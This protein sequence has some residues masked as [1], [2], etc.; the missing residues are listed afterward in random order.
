MAATLR[1][2]P[3]R[4]SGHCKPSRGYGTARRS[5]TSRGRRPRGR[6]PAELLAQCLEDRPLDETL[7]EVHLVRVEAHRTRDAPDL[8]GGLLD[9]RLDVLALQEVLDDLGAV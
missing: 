5:R 2:T 7:R 6:R 8:S 4:T 1:L 9:R 3:C